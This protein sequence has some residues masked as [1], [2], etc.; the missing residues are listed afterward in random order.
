MKR[1]CAVVLCL[2]LGSAAA[3]GQKVYKDDE[4]AALRCAN[5]IALTGVALGG[6]E[7]ISLEE[8]DVM[9]AL[10]VLILDRH[11][12]GTQA[13]KFAALKQMQNRRSPEATLED[14][15]SNAQ[16]CLERFPIN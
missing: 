2:A 1:L 12:S 4:A 11:V 14:Y 13:Q 16:H 5:M 15:R 3:A 9:L 8:Q 10:A 7:L 6:A